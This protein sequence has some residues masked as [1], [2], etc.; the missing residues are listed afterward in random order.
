MAISLRPT[1]SFTTP[2]SPPLGAVMLAIMCSNTRLW[3]LVKDGIISFVRVV[4]LISKTYCCFHTVLLLEIDTDHSQIIGILPPVERGVDP[5]WSV[6]SWCDGSSDRSLMVDPL[7]YFSFQPVLHNICGKGRGMCYHVC[8]MV[9]LRD[10][11]LLIGKS[12]GGKGG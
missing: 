8:E 10:P 5:W 1:S 12:S 2:Y 11:L 6:C 3:A 7:S 9:H 4:L